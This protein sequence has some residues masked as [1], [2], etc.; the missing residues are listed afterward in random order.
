MRFCALLLLP[1]LCCALAAAS[2]R[3]EPRIVVVLITH[4]PRYELVAA[5]RDSWRRG[6]RTLIVT[7]GPTEAAI[8]SPIPGDASQERWFQYPDD[9]RKDAWKKGDQ[10]AAAAF[11]IANETYGDDYDWLAYGDDDTVWLL[12]AA[13]ALVQGLDASVPYILADVVS[14][15]SP[16]RCKDKKICSLPRNA[17]HAPNASACVR[18][19]AVAPCTRAALEA[20]GTCAIENSWYGLPFPCGRNGALISRGMMRVLNSSQ[21]RT[22]CEEPNTLKGGGELRVYKCLWDE[23]YAMTDP[24]PSDDPSFCAMGFLH[25]NDVLAAA[26]AASVAGACDAACDRTLHRTV[27]LSVDEAGASPA[28]VRELHSAL[29][30]AD[31][32]IVAALAAALPGTL[33]TDAAALAIALAAANITGP[34]VATL[35]TSNRHRWRLF[36][37]FLAHATPLRLPLV[38]FTADA[39]TQSLCVAAIAAARALVADPAPAACFYP[40]ATLGG[41]DLAPGDDSWQNAFWRRIVAIAKP[42]SLALSA[43]THQDT[44]FVETD[45]VLRG[46]VL[47]ALRARPAAA[48]MTCAIATHNRSVGAPLP[49]GN[50]G[51]LFLRADSRLPALLEALLVRCAPQWAQ[52]DDQGELIKALLAVPPLAPDVP[53]FDCMDSSDG[54]TTTCCDYNASAGF[55]IHVAGSAVTEGKI[56]WLK[57]HGLWLAPQLEQAVMPAA[58]LPAGEMQAAQAAQAIQAA[59]PPAAP[60]D[61]TPPGEML[62]PLAPP[63]TAMPPPGPPLAV[64]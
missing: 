46:D 52:V 1:L 39:P 42:L 28:V 31:V 35:T 40:A 48:T 34:F 43:S 4:P 58:V 37:N 14:F 5:G 23:G 33:A 25:P 18:S 32:A 11:R 12:P 53:F 20:P 21:W 36:L 8:A 61:S 2:A 47:A 7:E 59:P 22:R 57:E 56:A 26:R 10:K 54:F 19:P 62:P 51:V 16:G 50:V 55:A 24:T 60:P 9:L 27:S 49:E 38:V 13:Q 63:P 45:I 6:Q 29:A 41:F 15:C 17:P 44:V 3:D 30:A 64:V